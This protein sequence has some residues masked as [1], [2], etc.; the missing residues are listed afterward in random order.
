MKA[1]AKYIGA[2]AATDFRLAERSAAQREWLREAF[3]DGAYRRW[4]PLAIAAAQPVDLHPSQRGAALFPRSS[5]TAGPRGCG[6]GQRGAFSYSVPACC[7]R[8]RTDKLPATAEGGVNRRRQRALADASL[9]GGRTER[10]EFALVDDPVAISVGS[11]EHEASP[12]KCFAFQN[13]A[14]AVAV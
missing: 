3:R 2:E 4:R 12:V 1:A 14:V 5:G 9:Y 7:Y 8:T 10:G 13:N 6:I 11:V